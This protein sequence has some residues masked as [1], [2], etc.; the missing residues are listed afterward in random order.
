MPSLS[1]QYPD[2]VRDSDGNFSRERLLSYYE[3][4]KATV[5][6]AA[7]DANLN[8]TGHRVLILVDLQGVYLG[9]VR[10]LAELNVPLDGGMLPSRL[11]H[12]FLGS[13]TD[14]IERKVSSK[15]NRAV[16]R[17]LVR[18]VF[19][20][21][22]S[23][24]Q[25]DVGVLDIVDIRAS[26]ELFYAPVPLD[27]IEWKLRKSARNGNA[28]ARRQLADIQN[29]LLTVHGDVRDYAQYDDFIECMKKGAVYSRSEKGFFNF[30]VDPKGLKSFDEK[31]VDTRIVIRAVDACHGKE[32][33]TI[34]IVSSDQDFVPLHE[35]AER[36][37]IGSYQADI[38]KF[39]AQDR[40][41]R[42]IK[43]LGE[44]YIPVAFE[45]LWAMRAV[46]EASGHDPF[47]G[48]PVDERI[49]EGI[50]S[51][52]FAALCQLHNEL[53]DNFHL[54]AITSDGD[55]RVEVVLPTHQ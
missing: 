51:R 16:F 27:R 19:R 30:Y 18:A 49:G 32:A 13:V 11:A 31:E 55:T 41:G 40:V 4:C 12:Y 5:E 25:P 7:R 52:E 42:R 35:R 53:N 45:P 47:N 21:E 9:L 37:G 22:A 10:W 15:L 3:A 20:K 26:M 44:S 43:E 28:D 48:V 33:D 36:S 34:C 6:N 29:G 24:L 50:S 46:C 2:E 54:K 14:A 17:D 8:I 1:V 23:G 38:S 39:A